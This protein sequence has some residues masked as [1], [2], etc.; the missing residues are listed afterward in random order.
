MDKQP[1]GLLAI[2]L[3]ATLALAAGAAHARSLAPL[4][5]PQGDATTT[6]AEATVPGPYETGQ[7]GSAHRI[8][9]AVRRLEQAALQHD[10]ASNEREL[11]LLQS[12]HDE[13]EAAIKTLCCGE[14]E[15]VAA[16]ESD[17]ARALTED[18]S[19]L[20]PLVSPDGEQFGPV[21]PSQSQLAQL[22]TEGQEVLRHAPT[23]ERL[24]IAPGP[25]IAQGPIGPPPASAGT[26]LAQLAAGGPVSL[27]TDSSATA[28]QFHFRF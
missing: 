16:L 13:L 15:R 22:V 17:I 28:A 5:E 20:G 26:S 12:A 21:A 1:S 6:Q 14:R 2:A 3:A 18:S 25:D 10:F 24:R 9:V 7:Q 4:R 19:Y 27:P 8:R 11:Q 23:V